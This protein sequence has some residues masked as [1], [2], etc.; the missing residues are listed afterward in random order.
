MRRCMSAGAFAVI[1]RRGD[2]DAGAIFIRV[3]D[4]DG[5]VAI[6]AP[7]PAGRD[8][9]DFGRRFVATAK[10]KTLNIEDAD[11]M[12]ARE[13][14]IDSDVWVVDVEDAAGQHHLGDDLVA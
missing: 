5:R 10:G 8:D 12:L 3:M 6:F 11:A 14:R 13:S 2:A 9:A 4:R 1:A 7:A